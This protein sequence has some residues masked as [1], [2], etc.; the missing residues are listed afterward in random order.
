MAAAEAR[1]GTKEDELKKTRRRIAHLLA[2]GGM[3]ASGMG[4]K[5]WAEERG[6]GAAASAGP[7]SLSGCRSRCVE[8]GAKDFPDDSA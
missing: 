1:S 3:R 7:L 2:L 4:G 8:K 5:A 6:I